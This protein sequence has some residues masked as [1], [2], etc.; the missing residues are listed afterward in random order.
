VLSGFMLFAALAIG[1]VTL[2]LTPLVHLARS[3]RPPPG[4]TAFAVVVGAL[5][6]LILIARS[7]K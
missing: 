1:L 7:W 5:P 2:I 6:W 3:V 4:I